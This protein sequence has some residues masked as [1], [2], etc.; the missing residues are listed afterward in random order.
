MFDC[1]NLA[2]IVDYIE[3]EVDNDSFLNHLEDGNWKSISSKE[4]VHM[5]RSLASSFEKSGVTQGTSVAIISDSSPFWL[6]VDYALQCLGAVSVPIFA[7]ISSSNLSFE[8]EDAAIEYVYIASQ[9]KY[10]ELEPHLGNMTLVLVKDIRASGPNIHKFLNFLGDDL[11]YTKPDIAPNDLATIIYTSGSTGVPKGVELSHQ[12]L[13]TQIIDT[14]ASVDL[15]SNYKALTFLPLAHI[16]ERMVMSY[17]LSKGLSV[18]F[19]D[20]VKNVANLLKELKPEIMTV[21]PRLLDKIYTKMHENASSAKGIKWLIAKAAFYRAN[22]KDPNLAK[23]T[24]IDGI[25]AKLV[26]TKLQDALG[27]NLQYL[28]TGGAPLSLPV[29]RFF[30][31]IGIP[32]YQGYGLTETSPVISVNTKNNNKVGTCGKAFP[33]VKV[34]LA[35]DGELLTKSPSVMRGYHKQLLKTKEV[36]DEDGWFHTGDLAKIDEEGYITLISRKKELFKTSTGKYVSAIAMEQRITANKWI[37]YAVVIADNKPY[38]SA[39]IFMDEILL[40][41]FAQKKGLESLSFEELIKHKRIQAIVMNLIK[42]L[43]TKLNHWEEIQKFHIVSDKV[44]IESGVL[45]PSMKVSRAKVE[46]IYKT[47]IDNFYKGAS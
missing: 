46:E 47:Q 26:Y 15:D 19:A 20:D 43:N 25:F 41:S 32:L 10:D 42:S 37:D 38:V 5:V 14:Q 35:S 18:F 13:I 44:S 1:T 24:I 6:I 3:N 21:V 11:S 8:L 34:K 40:E 31:N 2:E 39:L 28:I 22:S 23:D 4:F 16:F 12:N 9:E 17:Y 33:H 45:T 29:Y 30:H 36:L 7:N 27:G